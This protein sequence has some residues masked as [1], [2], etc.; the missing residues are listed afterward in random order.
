[1]REA[2]ISEIAVVL[3]Q[4]DPDGR[5]P[6]CPSPNPEE[7]DALRKGIDLCKETCADLLLATDPDC[8]RVGIA[9][10]D[11]FV[12]LK[13]VLIISASILTQETEA[14]NMDKVMAA[15]LALLSLQRFQWEQGCAA[16]AILE[17]EGVTDDLLRLCTSAAL[18]SDK[19][20]RVGV[21]EKNES[22]DDPASIGEALICAAEKTGNKFYREAAD[23]LYFYLKNR[24]P[25][26]IDGIIYHFNIKNEVWVDAYYMAPPFLC[27]YGDLDEAMKQIKGFRKYLFD[28]DVHML[29]HIW[30]D[31]LHDFGRHD[32]WG[33]GNGW[34]LAGL[35][36]VIAMLDEND[37]ENR[38]YLLDYLQKLLDGCLKHQREDGLFHDILDDPSSFVETNVAQMIAYTIY[39]GVMRG[40]LSEDYLVHADKARKAANDKVDDLG[41]VQGVCGMPDF[42]R[43]GVASEG[44]VFFILMETAAKEYYENH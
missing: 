8:D 44:Q 29:S 25:K 33:V 41:F 40:Y 23:K 31:D 16:Q 43:S 24:A 6:T 20:G 12:I 38:T 21:M 30:D 34:A 15:K 4:R 5:F 42:L 1:L 13:L 14:N 11:K 32:F 3:E 10:R 39:R 35:T 7:P 18:R 37:K 9:V 36:R 26:T 28:E 27:R 2:G 19:D 17:S 22:V